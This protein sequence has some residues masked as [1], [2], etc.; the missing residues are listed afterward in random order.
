MPYKGKNYDPMFHVKKGL[1][2]PAVR[3]SVSL[4]PPR[5]TK[6]PPAVAIPARI[7]I[8]AT[9]AVYDTYPSRSQANDMLRILIMDLPAGAPHTYRVEDDI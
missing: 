9:G 1:N 7:I 8:V 6:T 3:D 2:K 4:F 5:K